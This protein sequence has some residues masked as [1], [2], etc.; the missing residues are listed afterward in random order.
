M[1]YVYN[2]GLDSK[3]LAQFTEFTLILITFVFDVFRLFC[4]G[5]HKRD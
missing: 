4:G 5:H 2:E 3:L 1:N